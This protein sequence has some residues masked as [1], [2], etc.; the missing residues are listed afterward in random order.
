MTMDKETLI[1]QIK[2]VF[3]DLPMPKTLTDDSPRP[4]GEAI[5]KFFPGLKWQD[6]KFSD[7]LRDYEY[8]PASCLNRMTPEAYNY[9][10]PAFITMRLEDPVELDATGDFMIIGLILP[11]TRNEK[12]AISDDTFFSRIGSYTPEQKSLIAQFLDYE[13]AETRG[14][15]E[16]LFKKTNNPDAF[17]LPNDAQKALDSYWGQFLPKDEAT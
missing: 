11:S 2:I 12:W 8:D 17:K 15:L 6:V 9:Y 3:A 1:A 5:E 16:H 13:A 14:D 4:D 7:M 10:L